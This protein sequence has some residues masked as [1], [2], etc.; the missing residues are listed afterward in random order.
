MGS[1]K[2]AG[3]WLPTAETEIGNRSGL[4]RGGFELSAALTG[5]KDTMQEFDSLVIT[6]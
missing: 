1:L 4:N 6:C 3:V 2:S 5:L